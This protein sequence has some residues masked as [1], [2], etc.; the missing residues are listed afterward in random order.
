MHKLIALK[1]TSHQ[2]VMDLVVQAG[3]DVSDWANF[4]GGKEKAASNP[5]YCY[6]WSYQDHEEKIIVLN[7]WYENLTI[8]NGN[9]VQQLNLREVAENVKGTQKRRAIN[10]DFALQKAARTGWP[11]R[12]IICDGDVKNLVKENG[13]SSK[14]DKRFLDDESWFVESYSS[15]TGDCVL[16]RG[17]KQPAFIDQFD[18]EI[19]SR[20][21]TK[22]KQAT[23]A[24]YER[25]SN[26]R[27]AALNRASGLCEQCGERGFETA[28]GAVYLES[29]HIVP[30]SEGGADHPNNVIALCPNH[31]REAHYGRDALSTRKLL[32][33][34]VE[35]KQTQK[36]V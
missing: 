9:I 23:V 18:E 4:K 3:I 10:M 12:I 31:H 29:H 26:V 20:Q 6:E 14:A 35:P 32:Q 27:K 15:V 19:D 22:T 30:L 11:T 8:R 28:A 24:V 33:S 25:D 7:V 1:P 2:R 21:D 13:R 17:K 16:I 36:L 34:I 5:K